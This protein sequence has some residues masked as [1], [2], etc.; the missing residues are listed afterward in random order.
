MMN[1]FPLKLNVERIK[2]TNGFV[3]RA[4]ASQPASELVIEMSGERAIGKEKERE[5]TAS[6]REWIRENVSKA[7][8]VAKQM[9]CGCLTAKNKIYNAQWNKT[10]RLKIIKCQWNKLTLSHI[11]AISDRSIIKRTSNRH[12]SSY[13]PIYQSNK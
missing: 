10:S 13:R 11:H 1:A 2:K 9:F 6:E 4:R 5:R 7:V 12:H 8:P 3:V